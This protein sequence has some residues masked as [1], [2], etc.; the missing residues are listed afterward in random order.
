MM[1]VT[2]WTHLINTLYA[3][4]N[5]KEYKSKITQL[6]YVDEIDEE[7]KYTEQNGYGA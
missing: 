3:L 1:E 6:E 4:F 7:D 5:F 2:L